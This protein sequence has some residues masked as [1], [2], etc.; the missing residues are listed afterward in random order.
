[1]PP[2]NWASVFGGPA[3]TRIREPDGS[4]GQ[5]YLRVYAPEQPDWNWRDPRTAAL[6]DEVVRFLVRPW[7]GRAAHRR[8]TRPV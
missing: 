6:F 7:G 3:W 4:P 5:R 8:R 1:V 2:N